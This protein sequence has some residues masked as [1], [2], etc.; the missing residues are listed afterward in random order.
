MVVAIIEEN[1]IKQRVLKIR[2]EGDVVMRRALALKGLVLM[3]S[4]Q[5]LSGPL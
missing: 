1:A 5:T 4:L 2:K 3:P